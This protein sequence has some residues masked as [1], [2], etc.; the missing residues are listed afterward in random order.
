MSEPT[1]VDTSIWID[2]LRDGG[3]SRVGRLRALVDPEDVVLT[4]F[5]QLELLQGARDERQW[6]LLD[7]YLADQEYVAGGEEAFARAARIYFELRRA[8][9]T[10]RSPIDCCIAQIALEHEL[11]LLHRDRDFTA[12]G[13]LR[14]SLRQSWLSWS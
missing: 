2:V 14:P 5:T 1:I 11:P 9:R 10:V 8:G 7:R 4:R 3:G 12:I 6:E 13:E